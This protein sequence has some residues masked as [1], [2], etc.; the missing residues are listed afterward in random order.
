MTAIDTVNR[1]LEE[2]RLGEIEDL[3]LAKLSE[4]PEDS[5]FFNDVAKILGC[6]VIVQ[7]SSCQ[8][9]LYAPEALKAQAEL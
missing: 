4:S 7:C 9:I 2:D 8:R 3:W 5:T 6:T 1:L